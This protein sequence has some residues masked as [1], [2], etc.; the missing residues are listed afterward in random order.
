MLRCRSLRGPIA[1]V[2]RCE[3][4]GLNCA[5]HADSGPTKG[6][7]ERFHVLFVKI[8][9]PAQLHRA[10]VLMSNTVIT[11]AAVA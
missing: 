4:E 7:P 9:G 6:I 1:L 10:Y 8:W 11:A 2:R 5:R 3:P